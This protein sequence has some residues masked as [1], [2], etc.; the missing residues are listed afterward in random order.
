M[1]YINSP[2]VTDNFW[3]LNSWL[4]YAICYN[5]EMYNIY[6]HVAIIAYSLM[7]CELKFRNNND[8]TETLNYLGT[9]YLVWCIQSLQ[10]SNQELSASPISKVCEFL[11]K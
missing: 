3:I 8:G 1:L 11:Y 5:Y 7:L 2:S 9:S 4:L 10:V 6:L